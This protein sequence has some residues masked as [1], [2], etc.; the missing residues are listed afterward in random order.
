MNILIQGRNRSRSADSDRLHLVH[1]GCAGDLI[2][3]RWYIDPV[4]TTRGRIFRGC[5]PATLALGDDRALASLRA[6]LLPRH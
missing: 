6:E 1:L 4:A 5:Q 3:D 2:P